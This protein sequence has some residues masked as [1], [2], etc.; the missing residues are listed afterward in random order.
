MPCVILKPLNW[1]TLETVLLTVNC[2]QMF[3]SP[4]IYTDKSV[5]N[6][7]ILNLIIICNHIQ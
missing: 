7:W 6:V 3:S 5:I 1:P 4:W 2:N